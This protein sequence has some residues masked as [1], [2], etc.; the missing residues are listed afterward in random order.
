MLTPGC[1]SSTLLLPGPALQHCPELS[2]ALRQARGWG[3]STALTLSWALCGLYHQGQLY[4]AA[5][6]RVGTCSLGVISEG[7]L[8]LLNT[9]KR[10]GKVIRALKV[11]KSGNLRQEKLKTEVRLCYIVVFSGSSHPRLAAVYLCLRMR[12]TWGA[13]SQVVANSVGLKDQ[14]DCF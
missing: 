11:Q 2:R 14:G 13:R 3:S 10:L 4:C 7:I 12:R 6:A 9:V 8:L 1:S 5:Q